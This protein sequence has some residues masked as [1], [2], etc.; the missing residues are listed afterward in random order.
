MEQQGGARRR[1]ARATAA[2]RVRTTPPRAPRRRRGTRA[3]TCRSRPARSVTATQHDRVARTRSR[4]GGLRPAYHR[5]HRHIAPPRSGARAA[6]PAPRSAAAST[7]ARSGTGTQAPS[8]RLPCAAAQPESGG[9]APAAPPI[10]MFCGRAPLEPER[11]DDDVERPA[12]ER[13]RGR[14]RI[15]SAAST[16]KDER[17]QHQPERGRAR[18]GDPPGGHRPRAVRGPISRSMSRSSTWFSALA[19]PHASAPPMTSASQPHGARARRRPPRPS[20]TPPSA[21]AAT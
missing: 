10:T 1:S 15:A 21:P 18:W 2:R 13:Q 11:V 7:A 5:Q 19:P 9:I 6:A 16:A 12:A 14:Q 3:R 4:G 8:P 17:R 20:R